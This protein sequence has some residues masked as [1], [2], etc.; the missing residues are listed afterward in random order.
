MTRKILTVLAA[1]VF[2]AALVALVAVVGCL[3]TG[4]NPSSNLTSATSATGATGNVLYTVQTGDSLATLAKRFYGSYYKMYLISGANKDVLGQPLK[5]IRPG[6]IIV[7]PPDWSGRPVT[8]DPIGG[9][10]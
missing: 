3:P 2:T 1:I 6:Q 9:I 7:I 8:L 5:E 4:I 10:R